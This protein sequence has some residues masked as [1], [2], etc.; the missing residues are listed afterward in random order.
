M[1]APAGKVVWVGPYREDGSE[2]SEQVLVMSDES[3]SAIQQHNTIASAAYAGELSWATLVEQFGREQVK[4]V[5]NPVISDVRHLLEDDAGWSLPV[6]D[7]SDTTMQKCLDLREHSREWAYAYQPLDDADVIL[8]GL[9]D[10]VVEL[11]RRGS[12]SPMTEYSPCYWDT[13]DLSRIKKILAEAGWEIRETTFHAP[14][15]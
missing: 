10:A 5:L 12:V 3:Y 6:D 4:K 9:P 13:A 7:D 8:A 1:T 2:G 11:R 15:P 14:W